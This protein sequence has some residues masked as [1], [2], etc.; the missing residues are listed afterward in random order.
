LW[1]QQAGVNL[2]VGPVASRSTW[3]R[4]IVTD[5]VANVTMGVNLQQRQN[6]GRTSVSGFQTDLEYAPLAGVGLGGAY[7]YNRAFVRE[8]AANPALVGKFLPQVPTHRGTARLTYVSRRGLS[9]ALGI[10]V[11]G[12]QFDDDLN[13]R[14]VPPGTLIAAGHEADGKPGLPGYTLAEVAVSQSVRGR[15]DLLGG[16]QNLFARRYFV[17]T[18]P[19]TLGSPR[20]MTAGVRVRFASR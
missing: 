19:S 16:V 2:R 11:I 1:G 9:A 3:F 6:L 5:P 7:V 10:Q 12:R 17:G 15:I 20:M 14:V 18:L 4:N 8:F 13:A